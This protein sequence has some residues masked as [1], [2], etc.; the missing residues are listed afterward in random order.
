MRDPRIKRKLARFESAL[1]FTLNLVFPA[2]GDIVEF[3]RFSE[4]GKASRDTSSHS[5]SHN[6]E[7]RKKWTLIQAAAICCSP[8]MRFYL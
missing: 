8:P 2:R 1:P 5:H 6:S 4:V 7:P 3:R